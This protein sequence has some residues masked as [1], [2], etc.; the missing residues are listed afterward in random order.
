MI[1]AHLDHF[2]TCYV[3]YSAPIPQKVDLRRVR[4]RRGGGLIY[5]LLIYI[6]LVGEAFYNFHFSLFVALYSY[7]SEGG[8][9]TDS[10]LPRM[11]AVSIYKK[12]IQ[13]EI[14]ELKDL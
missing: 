6:C 9:A 10:S 8:F 1:L 11:W 12:E 13:I 4:R 7:V 3:S 2:W 14:Y 5:R